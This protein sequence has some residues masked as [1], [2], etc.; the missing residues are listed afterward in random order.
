MVADPLIL[1]QCVSAFWLQRNLPQM[2]A[3]LMEPCAVIQLSILLQRHENSGCKF[4]PW[5][6]R[7]VSEEPLTATY[8]P[9]RLK[10]LFYTETRSLVTPLEMAN[11]DYL[12]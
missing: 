9:P 2:F 7:F 11:Y 1:Q 8:G 6:I 10:T 5:R 12:A 3:L 4:R